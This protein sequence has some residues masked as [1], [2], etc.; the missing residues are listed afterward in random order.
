MKLSRVVLGLMIVVLSALSTALPAA[1]G[2]R[3]VAITKCSPAGV[4]GTGITVS[5]N[6]YLATNLSCEK[7]FVLTD[8]ATLDLRGHT[9]SGL[10]DPYSCVGCPDHAVFEQPGH[11]GIILVNGRVLNGHL[12][13]WENGVRVLSYTDESARLGRF[14]SRVNFT[15]NEQSGIYAA[16]NSDD[17]TVSH[18]VFERNGVGVL[19]QS[20]GSFTIDRSVFSDNVG[21]GIEFAAGN[22]LTVTS[23]AFTHNG[24]TGLF[25]I[26]I[27][28][29]GRLSKNTFSYNA[30]D[31]AVVG[32]G[33]QGHYL[34]GNVAAHNGQHGLFVSDEAVDVVDLGGNRAYDNA[35][36]PQCV[37][38]PCS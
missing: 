9:L 11:A 17:V 5:R 30:Q 27:L 24:G 26:D 6:S 22:N 25:D 32:G 20:S 31:G 4:Y 28:G 34:M 14:V 13:H 21:S 38:I 7:G 12:E 29:V 19:G 2:T 35:E 18:S 3:P 15:D 37:G 8:G 23:S 10:P 33:G 16:Y 1:A 36:S